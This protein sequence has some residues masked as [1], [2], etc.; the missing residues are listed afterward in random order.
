MEQPLDS[1]VGM[2]GDKAVK[3]TVFGGS[4]RPRVPMNM[5]EWGYNVVNKASEQLVPAADSF[6]LDF[7]GN[8][9]EPPPASLDAYDAM[10]RSGGIHHACVDAKVADVVGQGFSI[11][12]RAE[13][14]PRAGDGDKEINPKAGGQR[15]IYDILDIPMQEDGVSFLELLCSVYRDQ[16]AIGQGYIEF[17][18]DKHNNIDGIYHAPSVSVRIARGGT[19]NGFFQRDGLTYRYFAP[20]DGTGHVKYVRLDGSRVEAPVEKANG[21]PGKLKGYVASNPRELG[22]VARTVYALGKATIPDLNSISPDGTG[23]VRANE[24]LMFKHGTTHVTSYGEPDIFSAK[25]DFTVEQAVRKYAVAYF[26]TATVPRIV[27]S[28]SGDSTISKEVMKQIENWLSNR[29]PIKVLQQSLLIELPEE[30]TLQIDELTQ[31][32]LSDDTGLID[33]RDHSA[34]YQAA[35]HRVPMSAIPMQVGSNRAEVSIDNARYVGS[36]VRPAQRT[37]EQRLNWVFVNE[38]GVSDWVI[39]LDVP[40]LMD[41]ETKYRIWATGAQRGWLSINE[42]RGFLS[43]RPVKGGDFPFVLVPGQ[44]TVPIAN[45]EEIA[46]RMMDGAKR[47]DL[48]GTGTEQTPP[49]G[50]LPKA[51]A[52]TVLAGMAGAGG[53]A[54]LMLP[55]Y[56]DEVP[57]MTTEERGMLAAVTEQIVVNKDDVG[58]VLDG[59]D[60]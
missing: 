18:R 22:K 25:E 57:A 50:S 19:K 34:K 16:E 40:D 51:A 8:S 5:G 35:A 28:I 39:D 30:V 6:L 7:Q 15:K 31:A 27:M 54:A 14:F 26:D 1:D 53:A 9:C 23:V 60:E 13:L 3:V 52:D 56:D 4:G 49:K 47:G 42:I 36:V 11:R 45:L 44:G 10:Y 2:V 46:K 41:M 29:E 43:M 55:L 48:M 24:L 37:M 59:S 12:P 20:Y 38:T 32:Q 58:K 17:S 33:L 21:M